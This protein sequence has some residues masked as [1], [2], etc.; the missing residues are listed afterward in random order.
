MPCSNL[1]SFFANMLF[2]SF[3]EKISLFCFINNKILSIISSF[4]DHPMG[5]VKYI[6]I[7]R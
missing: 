6:K 4:V 3:L 2:N 5:G 7:F 1:E